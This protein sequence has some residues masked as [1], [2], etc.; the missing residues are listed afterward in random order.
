MAD[1][2]TM[3]V[4]TLVNHRATPRLLA[5]FFDPTSAFEGDLL[6]TLPGNRRDEVT[7]EDLFAVTL[8]DVVV[9]PLG[10]RRLLFSDNTRH[11]ISALLK[12]VPNDVDIWDGGAHLQLG[13]PAH[14]LWQL[15]QRTGDKIGPTTAGKI[16]ARKRPHLI[17]IGDSVVDAITGTTAPNS[18][19]HF[20]HQLQSSDRR[21]RID[22]LRPPG[23]VPGVPTLRILDIALWMWGSQAR[24]T[25]SVRTSLNLPATGWRQA[26]FIHHIT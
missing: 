24:V 16:L 4:D 9:A 18:W 22:E 15:L 26:G 21:A 8:L 11:K 5:A 14:Q 6:H 17:P 3:V 13:Q 7:L 12:Q 2:W 23:G 10:V 25:K 20:H 1:R 19:S